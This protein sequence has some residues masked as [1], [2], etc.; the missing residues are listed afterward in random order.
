MIPIGLRPL[1]NP[2]ARKAPGEPICSAMYPYDLVSPY[3]IVS[4]RFP[5]PSLEVRSDKIKLE[6]E[7]SAL[8]RE[9]RV[10]LL[11]RV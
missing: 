8:A 10:E 1:A 3:G 5:D 11:D 4:K 7:L 9:V 2:T 6:V